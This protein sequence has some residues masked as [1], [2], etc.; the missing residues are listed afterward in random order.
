[1]QTNAAMFNSAAVPPPKKR[2]RPRKIPLAAITAPAPSP[3]PALPPVTIAQPITRP[4][5]ETLL[6]HALA[7]LQ[8]VGPPALPRDN[9]RTALLIAERVSACWDFWQELS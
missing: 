7:L 9:D 6:K 4:S 5:R 2:G 8:E 1:M 3:V